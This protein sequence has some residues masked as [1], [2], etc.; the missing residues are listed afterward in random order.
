MELHIPYTMPAIN[1]IEKAKAHHGEDV[2]F[3]FRTVTKNQA[4]FGINEYR[5]FENKKFTEDPS[6]ILAYYMK[7]VLQ[8]VQCRAIG[9]DWWMTIFKLKGKKVTMIDIA[10]LEN[11]KVGTIND[12]YY[13]TNLYDYANYKAV[14][15]K[16][17]ADYAYRYNTP[18]EAYNQQELA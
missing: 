13:H 9:S 11:L 1:S 12:A 4:G 17:W 15:A 5:D 16:S 18:T 14:N 10:I 8:T 7:G 6:A 2:Q 3:E